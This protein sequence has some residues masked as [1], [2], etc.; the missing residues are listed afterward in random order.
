MK[1]D[2]ILIKLFDKREKI[3]TSIYVEQLSNN[4]YRAVEN[5]IFNCSLTFGTEF[6]TR[7]NSEGNHEIIKITKESDLITRRFILSPKYKNSAYQIL[8]DE[9]VKL[10][11]F[12]HVDFG[13]IVT[14]NIPKKFEFNIDQ[15]M[16]ELDIKLT[17]IIAN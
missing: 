3:T 1:L 14:I 11:G 6:T 13:G 2:P 7:I 15:L 16:K 4:I 8:G 12:W 9:L 10:G 5:E 17:E